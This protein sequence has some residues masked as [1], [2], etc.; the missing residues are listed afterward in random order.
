MEVIIFLR[1]LGQRKIRVGIGAVVAL[2]VAVGLGGSPTAP[3]GFAKTH[4]LIDTPRSELVA[5]A[6]VGMDSLWWRATL[7]AMRLG[8][9]PA[10]QQMAREIQVPVGQIAVTDLELTVPNVPA[11]L[12]VAATQAATVTPQPYVLTV[13]TDDVLPIV[14]IQAAAPD[15]AGAVRLAQA[16]VHALQ[17]GASP[18]DTPQVQGL[19]IEQVNPI[20]AI[21][22][23][24]GAGRSTMA[25]IALV[26][27]VLWCLG[28][29]V[30]PAIATARSTFSEAD[31]VGS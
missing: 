28:L 18:R 6:S 17:A 9:D 5:N 21:E 20:D 24:G 31:P 23:P 30:G 25:A 1:L 11:A 13:Q 7:M 16:A 29:A 2:A 4:V 27:F 10:R 8:T 22:I 14:W 19:N 12:P 15:R 3:S 26:I